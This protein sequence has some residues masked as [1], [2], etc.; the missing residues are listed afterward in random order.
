LASIRRSIISDDDTGRPT[1]GEAA[2]A[3]TPS[4]AKADTK[5]AV[6]KKAQGKNGQD[7][8]EALAGFDVAADQ[9]SDNPPHAR[10][11]ADLI[12]PR[13]AMRANAPAVDGIDHATDAGEDDS[14]APPRPRAPRGLEATSAREGPLLPSRATAVDDTAGNPLDHTVLT[15]NPRSLEDLVRD[16]LKPMLK[17]WL[18]DNLPNM[19]EHL[20]RA[21]IERV[22][23][24]RPPRLPRA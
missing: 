20:V 13:E 11:T 23:L 2:A 3:R 22:S 24:N 16:M 9:D 1:S 19:V 17:A 12:E 18:D 15:Q 6:A 5:K 21:E 10:P 7:N 8:A 14:S 4:R